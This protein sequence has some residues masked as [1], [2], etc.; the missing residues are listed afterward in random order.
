M[1]AKLTV[2]NVMKACNLALVLKKSV[3]IGAQVMGRDGDKG[4]KKGKRHE[5]ARKLITFAKER[6]AFAKIKKDLAGTNLVSVSSSLVLGFCA[7][8]VGSVA[9][10][11]RCCADVSK[12]CLEVGVVTTPASRA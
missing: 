4:I 9:E 2:Q 8:V 3:N 7:D 1:L 5:D 11:R 10:C 12:P 6:I